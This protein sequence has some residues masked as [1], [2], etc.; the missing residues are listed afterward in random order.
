[1]Q[2]AVARL[3]PSETIFPM[4]TPRVL[5]AED[6]A[7]LRGVI[8]AVLRGDG[9]EVVEAADGLALLDLIETALTKR[10]E[11]SE[12]FLV[13]A[14]INMPGLTGLDVLAILRCAF[15]ITPVILIT[16]F[17]DDETRAEAREL[18]AAGVLDKPFS[19]DA[20]RAA[21]MEAAPLG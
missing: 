9:Y 16:A 8:A 3:E 4:R 18:G 17:G 21:V 6:D 20:L 2:T 19:I 5:V 15:A 13:I 10:R 14:D 1:M 11:R 7:T 12:A